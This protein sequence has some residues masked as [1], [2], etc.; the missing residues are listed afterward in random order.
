MRVTPRLEGMPGGA[1][2]DKMAEGVAQIVDLEKELLRRIANLEHERLRIEDEISTLPEQQRRVI[3][4]RYVEE[5]PWKK[6]ARE[7]HYGIRHAFKIHDAALIRLGGKDGI[8][9][10]T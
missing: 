4:A 10:H 8:K 2:R 6:V 9:W 1:D 7:T 3:T 5:K